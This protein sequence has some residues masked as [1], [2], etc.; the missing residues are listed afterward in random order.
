MPQLRLAVAA[1][2][3]ES[4]LKVCKKNEAI[5]DEPQWGDKEHTNGCAATSLTRQGNQME[6]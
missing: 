4:G 1:S 2:A 6:P 5:R 3:A